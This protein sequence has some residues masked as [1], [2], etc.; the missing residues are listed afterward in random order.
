GHTLRDAGPESLSGRALLPLH[1]PADAPARAVG[2]DPLDTRRDLDCGENLY[3]GQ[4]QP[5]RAQQSFRLQGSLCDSAGTQ[6]RQGN[7]ASEQ[8]ALRRVGKPPNAHRDFSSWTFPR[9]F[10]MRLKRRAKNCWRRALRSV[11]GSV[12]SQAVRFPRRPR[13]APSLLLKST[14][15]RSALHTRRCAFPKVST[16]SRDTSTPTA[17]GA[18]RLSV[19]ATSVPRRFAGRRSASCLARTKS[20]AG[21]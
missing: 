17:A 14:I 15:N 9:D 18:T 1:R 20:I 19:S 8:Q 16:G 2:A 7:R 6:T 12:N 10:A 3:L 5:L 21:S 13:S 4:P 11:I